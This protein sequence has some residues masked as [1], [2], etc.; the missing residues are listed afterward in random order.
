MGCGNSINLL[1]SIRFAFMIR[2]SLIASPVR[3]FPAWFSLFHSLASVPYTRQTMICG[4][5][6]RRID[7]QLAFWLHGGIAPRRCSR[8]SYSS[9]DGSVKNIGVDE[10]QKGQRRE[11][12]ISCLLILLLFG[13][14][15]I[16]TYTMPSL[17]DLSILPHAT[18]GC[19]SF[20][21]CP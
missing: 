19:Q 8:G 10:K 17:R 7:M 2:F 16:S 15:N 9:S 11:L 18:R 6:A 13:V 20:H 1:V 14:L 21:F 5:G 4:C 3:P 12:S